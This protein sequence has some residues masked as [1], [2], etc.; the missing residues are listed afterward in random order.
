M[1]S[2]SSRNNGVMFY[3]HIK[4]EKDYTLEGELY[5]YLLEQPMPFEDVTE[6]IFLLEA[7]MDYSNYP[8]AF[9]KR[10]AFKNGKNREFE[11]KFAGETG[12]ECF[13]QNE[14]D[15]KYNMVLRIIS[16]QNSS[17]QGTLRRANEET[18]L[19]FNSEIELIGLL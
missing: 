3:L 12:A 5:N 15:E 6:L 18:E 4:K 11:L 13:E 8:Q 9:R 1:N 7:I 2:L 17:W 10:R 16:R 19:E 14:L